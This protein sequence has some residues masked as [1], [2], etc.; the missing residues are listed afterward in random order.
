M[1]TDSELIRYNSEVL[2][3]VRTRYLPDVPIPHP[4]DLPAQ[5]ITVPFASG[6]QV[7]GDLMLTNRPHALL[8]R[9]GSSVQFRG[10]RAKIGILA[11]D[12]DSWNAGMIGPN[13]LYHVADPHALP[14]GSTFTFR[15]GDALVIATPRTDGQAG[16]Y[17]AVLVAES[18]LYPSAPGLANMRRIITGA[19][20]A[21]VDLFLRQTDWFPET[22]EGWQ[23]RAG[24]GIINP[25]PPTDETGYGGKIAEKTSFGALLLISDLPDDQKQKVQTRLLEISQDME[26]FNINYPADG[27]HGNGRLFP[28]LLRAHCGIPSRLMHSGFSELQQVV[29]NYPGPDSIEG[30]GWRHH[31]SDAVDMQSSY[32]FCCTANRWA[33]AALAAQFLSVG[34]DAGSAVAPWVR[35]TQAYLRR[36]LPQANDWFCM[37]GRSRALILGNRQAL[38]Y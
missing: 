20:A 26:H 5:Q 4:D 29:P 32:V 36:Y 8:V 27:G 34:P 11:D 37:H 15:P 17:E 2:R 23:G 10:G 18:S 30:M 3:A 7:T 16:L 6:I 9:A 14:D 1:A 19:N 35:Y 22:A 25:Q 13:S 21:D 38:G 24:H 28:W 31:A 12:R 33:G